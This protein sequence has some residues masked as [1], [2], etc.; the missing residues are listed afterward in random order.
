MTVLF[1]SMVFGAGCVAGA[2]VMC[3]ALLFMEAA[4]R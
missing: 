2:F 3:G 4:K 1:I